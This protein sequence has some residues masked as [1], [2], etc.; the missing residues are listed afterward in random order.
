MFPLG[1]VLFPHLLLPL[2]VFEDRYRQ[3]MQTCLDHD[4]RFGVVLIDRGSE[5]GGGDHRTSVGTAADIVEARETDDGRW[6]VL[7]VGA[8]R[9]RVL[10]WLPDAPY[11][12]AE[13]ESVDEASWSPAADV[14]FDV[15]EKAVRRSLTL[16]AELDE[17][18]APMGVK[19]APERPVAAWQLAAISPLGPL[20]RQ[21]LL[22]IDDPVARLGLLADLVEEE[23]QVLAHRLGGA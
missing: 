9:I 2:H 13:V 21:R 20:D 11:P 5:V 10:D 16:L 4:R 14:I 19:L 15:A 8:E 3:M 23:C 22:G 12:R 17:P 7:A 18:A 6:E 1:S